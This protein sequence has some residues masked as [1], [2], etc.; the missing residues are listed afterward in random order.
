MFW[1]HARIVF[2]VQLQL[3]ALWSFIVFAWSSHPPPPTMLSSSSLVWSRV[4][5]LW[6]NSYLRTHRIR[7]AEWVTLRCVNL[8]CCIR[9][10]SRRPNPHNK[11]VPLAFVWF[12]ILMRF[13]S[14]FFFFCLNSKKIYYLTIWKLT[15]NQTWYVWQWRSS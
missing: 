11:F 7:W 9:A 13:K 1:T 3:V 6:L 14:N 8:R 15:I 2:R 4:Q 10:P 12:S 5:S